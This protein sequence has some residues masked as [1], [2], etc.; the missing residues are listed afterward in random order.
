MPTPGDLVGRP[1]PGRMPGPM[2]EQMPGASPWG[3]AH[4]GGRYDQG[5]EMGGTWGGGKEEPRW[6]S[7][8]PWSGGRG[9]KQPGPMR[10]SPSWGDEPMGG[11]DRWAPRPGGGV[12]KD[13]IWGSKQFRIL[14]EMGFRKEDVETALRQTNMQ[15]EDAL[16]MLNAV[17]R[18]GG[19]MPGRGLPPDNMFGPR[20]ED[21]FGGPRGFP[22]PGPMPPYPAGEIPPTTPS[23]TGPGLNNPSRNIQPGMMMNGSGPGLHNP[24]RPQPSGPPSTSQL[25]VLVQQIQMA[26]QA[27]HLNPQ[28]LNQPLAPQTLLL[29]NQ[30]LQQIKQLQS[31]Q[32]QHVIAQQGQRPGGP[33]NQ[34]LLALTVQITKHKQQ[35]QNLQN[36]ITAQQAQYL[37]N[38]QP[39]APPAGGHGTPDDLLVGG[40][41]SMS[42]GPGQ[43]Q[44]AGGSKVLKIIGGDK[45][46][47]EFPK[48]P[49]APGSGR[50][51]NSQSSPN[52][53]LE[54]NGPWSNAHG[55]DAGWPSSGEKPANTSTEEDNFGIPEFVPG[56]AWK[57]TAMKDPSEDPTLTPG[58]VAPPS[59]AV[60]TAENSLGLTS[61]TWSFNSTNSKEG[62]A[63]SASKEPWG[64]PALPTSSSATN[65]TAMGQDLWGQGRTA[66]TGKQQTPGSTSGWPSTNGLS[67]SGGW[68]NGTNGGNS[69]TTT[70]APQGAPGQ[71]SAWLL[72]KNLTTQIDGSTLN[73]LCKQHG[74]L[75]N[76]H[77]YL[78]H[79][80]ALVKYSNGQ[81][82]K[83]VRKVVVVASTGN[84]WY[85]VAP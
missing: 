33:S 11:G 15:L 83:K 74:P 41:D 12:S 77:L 42:M 82:A 72:L 39:Q 52:L 58:S 25:R 61:S 8:E 31:Y 37:K 10:S 3:Q 30:L 13:M 78:P 26:V 7:D 6:S 14:V 29:L 28:I 64:N 27:G 66:A 44:G 69:T 2:K 18:G 20:G 68:S 21:M 48:A 85:F 19:G 17:G 38:Q 81:E 36:Q 59:T 73:T 49:G 4:P 84:L 80:I 76:F 23:M 32:Q 9:P 51:A 35:I 67:S 5:G 50:A 16:E 47:E 22:G 63:N 24:P 43:A 71:A 53:L 40:M 46:S 70:T 79:G 1:G 75:I 60:T 45:F 57:G 54:N 55:G 34:A 65:L 56:K 62:G